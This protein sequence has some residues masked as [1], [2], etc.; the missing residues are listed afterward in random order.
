MNNEEMIN[1]ISK[2]E[3]N[4][5]KAEVNQEVIMKTLSQTLIDVN[6]RLESMQQNYSVRDERLIK[7]VKDTIKIGSLETQ[8]KN[9]ENNKHFA[10]GL[11]ESIK[12]IEEKANN[13]AQ[14]LKN[15]ITFVKRL[16]GLFAFII[17]IFLA[18]KEYI[19]K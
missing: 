18:I 3:V 10:K 15:E 17:S 2:V 14:Q 5:A 4:Q 1:R 11:V 9:E 13:T 7:E 12:K 19:F 8:I 16:G 6:R